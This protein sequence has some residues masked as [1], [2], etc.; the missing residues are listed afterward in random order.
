MQGVSVAAQGRNDQAPP[1]DRAQKPPLSGL[2]LQQRGRVAMRLPRISAGSDLDRLAAHLRH[3]IEHL[4]E[5]HVTE[6]NSKDSD[7]HR[8]P[9][10]LNS[11][12][13]ASHTQ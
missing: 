6:Q 9:P 5:G 13:P 10:R 8:H 12:G 7:F 2:L 11:V 1:L 4:L 3:V